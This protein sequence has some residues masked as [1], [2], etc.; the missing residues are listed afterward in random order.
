MIALVA[1]FA[2]SCKSEPVHEHGYVIEKY[3]DTNHWKECECGEKSDI[4]NHSLSAWTVSEEGIATRKC[5]CGY[6]EKAEGKAVAVS[7]ASELTAALSEANTKIFLDS[8]IVLE[9]TLKFNDGNKHK[10]D[11]N[12]HSISKDSIPV[13]IINAEVEFTGSGTIQETESDN[14]AAILLKGS[15]ADVADYSVVTVGKDITLKGWS[16]VMVDQLSSKENKRQAYGVVVNMY[17]KIVVPSEETHASG[18]GIYVNGSIQDIGGNNPVINIDGAEIIANEVGI[19]AAGY[20]K[21]N[22]KNAKIEAVNALSL[23]AGTFVID[24]GSYK[25]TGTFAD[26]SEDTSNGSVETGA[27]LSMTS[28]DRYAH[29]LDVTVNDGTFESVN[30]YAVYEGIPNTPGTS[31]PVATDS[32]VTLAINGG[33]FEGNSEKGSIKLSK[34]KNSKIVSSGVF[35]SDPSAYLVEGAS[36]KESDGLW[37][38]SK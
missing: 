11:L 21:W 15:E 5:A 30:G 24:G 7:N 31:I 12:G 9:N 36:V 10:I 28:N 2:I 37:S 13:Y 4:A 1:V 20:A 33:K 22:I 26:P 29:K 34:I 27:A 14:F 23:K 35:N 6:I 3:D 16:G 25:S 17:G 19:Y 18:N 32:Y 38:V 8:D